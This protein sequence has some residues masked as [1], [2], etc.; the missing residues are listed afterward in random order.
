M[1]KQVFYHLIVKKR[2]ISLFNPF[3]LNS[4]FLFYSKLNFF[5]NFYLKYILSKKIIFHFQKE[6]LLI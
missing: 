3:R 1:F 2:L 6:N 5:L 4:I